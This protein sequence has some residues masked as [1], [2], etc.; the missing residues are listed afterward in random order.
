MEHDPTNI[1]DFDPSDPPDERDDNTVYEDNPDSLDGTTAVDTDELDVLCLQWI[2][3]LFIGAAQAA[4][5]IVDA[6]SDALQLYSNS[7]YEKQPYHS[8]SLSGIAWVNDF[9]TGH[10]D[11]I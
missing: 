11:R 3:K 4:S 5:Y 1:A 2:H 7:Y 10:P 9:L 8:S 6:T